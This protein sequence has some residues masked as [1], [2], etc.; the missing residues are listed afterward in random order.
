MQA[1]A[2]TQM[3]IPG[4]PPDPQ[5]QALQQELAK[6]VWG[7]ILELLKNDLLRS[8]RIDI[9]TNSTVQPEAAE[10]QKAITEMMGA[11]GQTL[12]GLG[13]LV[14]N[15]VLPFQAA[16]SLLLFIARRFRYGSEIEDSIQAMQPPKP[17][18]DGG[19]AKAKQAQQ[20]MEM[21]KQMAVKEVDHKKKESEMALKEQSMKVE[22]EQKQREMDLQLREMQLQ[23]KEQQ[24][25]MQQN[26]ERGML[27]LHKQ[28]AHEELETKSKVADMENK[29]YKT[30][31]VVNAKADS[32]LGKAVAEMQ[33]ITTKLSEMVKN[34]ADV[35]NKM[36]A[37]LSAVIS[38][39]GALTGGMK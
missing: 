6:P 17:P 5:M 32:A 35:N 33:G 24:F 27:D 15:G 28:R 1:Q 25:G 29:K 31:N 13:P 4:Q 20:Q 10:D 23:I 7:Q 11:I 38:G 34:Q 26:V 39:G 14:A 3:Q 16:Q 2:L 36:L 18:D 8:Y 9:E 12:N 37:Q 30:E 22:M 19:E 21:D